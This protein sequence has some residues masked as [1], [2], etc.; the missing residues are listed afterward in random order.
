MTHP[1]I[2]IKISKPLPEKV[3]KTLS[4][5]KERRDLYAKG[6]IKSIRQKDNTRDVFPL[7]HRQSK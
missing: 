6:D 2:H 3:E 1:E 7:S 4:E 5:K